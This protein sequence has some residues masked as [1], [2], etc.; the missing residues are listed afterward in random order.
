MK[1][2]FLEH[3]YSESLLNMA[4]KRARGTD[5]DAP[6]TKKEKCKKSARVCFST[7]YRQKA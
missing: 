2:R 5:R 7:E 6:L 3:G 4:D 1:K